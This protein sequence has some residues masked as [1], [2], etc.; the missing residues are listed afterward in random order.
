MKCDLILYTFVQFIEQ[1][2]QIL[3]YFVPYLRGG[4][5]EKTL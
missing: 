4:G 2:S 3:K 5:L 1:N